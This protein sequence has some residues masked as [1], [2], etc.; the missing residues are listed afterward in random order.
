MGFERLD[1]RHADLSLG[2]PDLDLLAAVVEDLGQTPALGPTW[3]S[4]AARL[5]FSH[6]TMDGEILLHSDLNPPI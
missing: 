3:F 4:R 6:P 1:G 2:S 5:G